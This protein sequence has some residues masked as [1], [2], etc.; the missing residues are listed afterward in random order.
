MSHSEFLIRSCNLYLVHSR[1]DICMGM[2]MTV[3][4]LE[5]CSNVDN[6]SLKCHGS[7]GDRYDFAVIRQKWCR[8]PT[9]LLREWYLLSTMHFF[10]MG[11]PKLVLQNSMLSSFL[12]LC[13]I[14]PVVGSGVDGGSN[15]TLF[16]FTAVLS[17]MSL[18][19]SNPAV[20]ARPTGPRF[21]EV[22]GEQKISETNCFHSA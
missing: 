16:S 19:R 13:F 1:L 6:I 21:D 4:P 17:V 18:S 10:E 15:T 9:I 2:G 11:L 20:L 12:T 7:C 8:A 14:K 22:S 3:I 5:S